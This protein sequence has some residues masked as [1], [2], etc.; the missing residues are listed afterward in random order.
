MHIHFFGDV[1]GKF[2]FAAERCNLKTRD[3]R[4]FV[5]RKVVLQAENCFAVFVQHRK[6]NVVLAIEFELVTCECYVVGIE[7]HGVGVRILF[8]CEFHLTALDSR[9]VPKSNRNLHVHKT[10][11]C[12]HRNFKAH[13]GTRFERCRDFAFLH[14]ASV[15]VEL[16][17]KFPVVAWEKVEVERLF[18]NGM[19]EVER[20]RAV[21]V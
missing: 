16:G 11:K 19:H 8:A 12:V 9:G 7:Y 4:G 13:S 3:G 21:A 20:V 10:D 1:N 2:D 6:R 14:Q 5:E 18:I 17:V 15:G